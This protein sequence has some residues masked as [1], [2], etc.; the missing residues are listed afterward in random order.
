PAS[1]TSEATTATTSSSSDPFIVPANVNFVIHAKADNVTYDAVNYNNVNGTLEMKDEAILLKDVR[2][3]ALDGTAVI[4][5]SYSTR[6]DKKEPDIGLSYDI[7]DM[8]VQKVFNAFMT[9]KAL[10]PI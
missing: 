6:L 2:T 3:N 10:M 8:S 9:V 7:K 1:T 4:N 5:G